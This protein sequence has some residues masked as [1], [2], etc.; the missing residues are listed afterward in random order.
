KV[1]C[2]DALFCGLCRIRMDS[3]EIVTSDEYVARETAAVFKRIARG[4][5]KLER[6]ALAF[7]H[8]RGV[9]HSCSCPLFGFC[10]GFLGDLIFPCFEWRFH[11][12]HLSFR[13]KSRNPAEQRW[14]TQRDVSTSLGM[15]ELLLIKFRPFA[16]VFLQNFAWS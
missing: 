15:T 11:M 1:F 2:S 14:V 5:G 10:A 9:D 6:L 4:L 8:L 13:A 3:N 12:I 16:R 7:G